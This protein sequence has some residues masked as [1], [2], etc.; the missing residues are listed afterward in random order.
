M[1][2]LIVYLVI[3]ITVFCLF[4]I[5]TASSLF[6]RHAYSEK[7]IS[8]DCINE[9]ITI[10]TCECGDTYNERNS[11]PIGHNYKTSVIYPTCKESGYTIHSCPCGDTYKD[12]FTDKL[13]HN[14]S[15]W[16]IS[17]FPT[18]E[19]NGEE[20]RNC[21]CGFEEKRVYVCEHTEV[22]E[23]TIIPATC[24]NKGKVSKK[25]SLC[26]KILEENSIDILPHDFTNWK[27]T[28]TATP[29][30][31][32]EKTRNCI[33]CG[34]TE[35]SVIEFKMAGANS[36]YIPS[37]GINVNYIVADFTQEAVDKNDVICN[38]TRLN[39]NNP[40]VLGH[41]TGS[42]KKLYNATIGSNIYFY[43]DRELNTYKIKY[44]ERAIEINGR[45]EFEGLSTGF[46]LLDENNIDG[47]NLRL[48]TCYQDKELGKIRWIVFAEKI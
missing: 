12:N 39:A 43:V 1:K 18:A 7:I 37:A 32:G 38:Y 13:E 34:L 47:E 30:T 27:T 3:V 2:K 28:K 25:C 41:N 10:Y 24:K 17:V 4:P 42:L 5:I 16:T 40:I 29:N 11:E 22:I 36:I 26:S 14:F 31:T 9:G 15:D 46:K 21:E 33:N 35:N 44:S 19:L 20:I 45:T 8:P 48:Y 23:E 6:H